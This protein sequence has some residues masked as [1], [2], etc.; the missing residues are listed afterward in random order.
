MSL[1][2]IPELQAV[3]L[4]PEGWGDRV[5]TQ[6]GTALDATL[7]GAVRAVVDRILMPSPEELP[8][9]RA[10]AEVFL[11]ADLQREPGRFFAFG[12]AARTPPAVTGRRLRSL[13]GGA[14]LARTV[15]ADYRPYGGGA[16]ESVRIPLEHWVH[17]SGRPRATVL[18][19]HGF[20]MGQPRFDAIALFAA[21]LFRQG[22]DVALMTLPYHGVRTPP[23][24]RF[25]GERFAAPD[26]AR[27]GAAVRQ[28][29]FEIQVVT[30]W[31]CEQ[32]GAPV[33]LLGLS[34]GGYLSALTAGLRDDLEFVIAMVPPVCIG[35]LAWRFFAR[36]RQHRAGAPAAFTRDELRRA[37]AVHSPLTYP[38][39]LERERVMIIAGRGDQIV[40]PEHPHALWLH[41]G[42]PDI[43]WFS[44]SH[45]APFGRG[46]IVAAIARHLT[47]IGVL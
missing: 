3:R 5:L 10:T 11:S 1:I 4:P 43:H 21:P 12:D 30:R 40:P 8:A 38:L 20:T 37:Y 31:L 33:G 14:V 15:A 47:R 35:D 2:E 18:A 44:G 27:M 7:L 6:V 36:S 46:R 19:L 39:R 29:I 13:D 26:V 34:L 17:D 41:W 25:S 28:A 23:D 42:E 22:L 32:S 16:G 9:M 24:S 45:L